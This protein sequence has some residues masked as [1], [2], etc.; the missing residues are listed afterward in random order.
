LFPFSAFSLTRNIRY[1]ILNPRSA[2][3]GAIPVKSHFVLFLVVVLTIPI[4]A[5]D[6]MPMIPAEKLTEAQKKGIEE[7]RSQ[8]QARIE[9]CR[10]GVIDAAKCTP[11]YFG[12]HGPMVP[13]LRSPE[14]MVVANAMMNYLEYKTV[15]PPKLRELVVLMVAREWTAQYLWNSHYAT[16]LEQGLSPELVK[17]ISEGRRPL[18]M[19][20]E[21]ETVYDF[22]D[23]LRRN[24]GVS[25]ATYSRAL[26]KFGEQGIIDLV[27]VDGIY[28]YMAKV[29]NV[30]HTPAP[31][32]ASA[33]PLATFPR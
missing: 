32:N 7:R 28:S 3:Q 25:D 33:P 4:A 21:E 22:C 9:A 5:Q 18:Q 23:E 20:D 15:L 2:A 12:V 1:P 8:Q 16:G 31:K 11:E 27:S 6:R 30:A 26:A 17:A 13:L 14:V 29:M 19:S 24:H 10:N